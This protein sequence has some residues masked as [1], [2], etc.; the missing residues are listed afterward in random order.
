[1]YYI[2][3]KGGAKSQLRSAN[4][5]QIAQRQNHAPYILYSKYCAQYILYIAQKYLQTSGKSGGLRCGWTCMAILRQRFCKCNFKY[6]CA[7]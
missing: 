2:K 4:V 6:S 5:W 3:V 7:F 1:M